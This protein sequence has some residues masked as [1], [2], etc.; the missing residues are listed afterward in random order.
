MKIFIDKIYLTLDDWRDDLID[1]H[2]YVRFNNNDNYILILYRSFNEYVI[3]L[4]GAKLTRL[5]SKI[6]SIQQPYYTLIFKSAK[7]AMTYVDNLFLKY[8]MYSVFI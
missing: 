4:Y 3:E 8:K 5:A 2:S 6:L 7:E 1:E